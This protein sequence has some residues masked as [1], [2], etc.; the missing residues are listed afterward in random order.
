MTEA[1]QVSNTNTY[2]ANNAIDGNLADY[3][4]TGSQLN[5]WWYAKF[6]NPAN[7]AQKIVIYPRYDDTYFGNFIQTSYK[8]VGM[9]IVYYV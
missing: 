5:A 3:S 2:V 6:S 4:I 9:L 1:V 8:K 7:S